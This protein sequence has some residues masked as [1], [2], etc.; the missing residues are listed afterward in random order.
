MNDP[1]TRIYTYNNRLP[2]DRRRRSFN[3]TYP[4]QVNLE[5]RKQVLFEDPLLHKQSNHLI[6][7]T[8]VQSEEERHIQILKKQN[9]KKNIKK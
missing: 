1:F 3:P 7:K 5:N 4:K 6:S 8:K 2:K 9:Y